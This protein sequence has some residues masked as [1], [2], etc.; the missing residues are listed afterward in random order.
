[1]ARLD[2]NGRGKYQATL[3]EIEREREKAAVELRG[4]LEGVGY[5]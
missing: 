3:A 5:V 1:M 4:Y 2:E